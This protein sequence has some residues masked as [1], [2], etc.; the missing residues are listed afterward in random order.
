MFTAKRI[1]VALGLCYVG[2]LAVGTFTVVSA[3]EKVVS[4]TTKLQQQIDAQTK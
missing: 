2:Y 4:H 1:L 3:A